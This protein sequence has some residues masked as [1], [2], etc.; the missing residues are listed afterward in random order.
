MS[1]SNIVTCC[2]IGHNDPALTL[3]SRVLLCAMSA[4]RS[5]GTKFTLPDNPTFIEFPR[6]D[7]DSSR[8]PPNTTRIVDSERHVNYMEALDLD[9]PM[10]KKW[11][12]QIAD[13]VSLRLNWD[14]TSGLSSFER[15]LNLLLGTK[16]YVLKD[17]P[18]GYKLFDHLKGPVS[19]PRHDVYFFGEYTVLALH[20]YIKFIFFLQEDLLAFVPFQNS[21]P[22]PFG[23]S[24]IPALNVCVNIALKNLRGISPPQCPVSY[25]C[26]L[27]RHPQIAIHLAYAKSANA[28]IHKG[29]VCAMRNRMLQSPKS[30]H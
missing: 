14:G 25:E 1:R 26:Q 12:T 2:D 17:W 13:A 27:P 22:M 16:S 7:G 6:S 8:R 4:H 5:L 19:N 18:S 21:Y 9:T 20:A 30:R 28:Q 24:V 10:A 29:A 15:N 11:R 23:Y 3:T